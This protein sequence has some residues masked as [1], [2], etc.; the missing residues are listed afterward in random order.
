MQSA[1]I[2]GDPVIGEVIF[3]GYQSFYSPWFPRGANVAKFSIEVFAIT[4][5]TLSW[6][7]ETKNSEDV[8]SSAVQVG[9]TQTETAAGVST[10]SKFTGFKELVRYKFKTG[11]TPSLDWVHFRMLNPAWLYN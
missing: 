9:S 5:M 1:S 3:E 11:A 4:G 10:T 8:D 2:Q 6:E 7:V